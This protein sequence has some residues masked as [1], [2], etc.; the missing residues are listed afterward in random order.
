MLIAD[1][2]GATLTLVLD[3]KAALAA[4]AI[5]KAH[6]DHVACQHAR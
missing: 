3:F 4:A 2:A 5:D 6:T 1:L